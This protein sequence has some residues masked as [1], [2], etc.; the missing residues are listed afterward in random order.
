MDQP[1][2]GSGSTPAVVSQRSIRFIQSLTHVVYEQLM[3]PYFRLPSD[4]QAHDHGL[5][6]RHDGDVSLAN[7]KLGREFSHS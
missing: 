5:A 4:A 2:H 7:S 3:I 1:Q 6:R